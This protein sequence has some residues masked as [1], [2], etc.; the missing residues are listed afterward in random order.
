M[1][2][3]QKE[4]KSTS[5]INLKDRDLQKSKIKQNTILQFK[6]I[7][8]FIY[9]FSKSLQSFRFEM[10]FFLLE[11][12]ILLVDCSFGLEGVLFRFSSKYM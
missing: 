4:I 2:N 3:K 11:K 6:S 10:V 7:K 12:I 5:N 8:Y 9:Y 1:K